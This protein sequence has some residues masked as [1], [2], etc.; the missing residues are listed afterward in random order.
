MSG[1]GRI[2]P[3]G[4][5]RAIRLYLLPGL[6]G[7]RI[8]L[9]SLALPWVKVF[10]AKNKVQPAKKNSFLFRRIVLGSSVMPLI[11]LV[12]DEALTRNGIRDH[13]AW[14]EIGIDTVLTARNGIEALEVLSGRIPD[15]LITDIRMPRMDGIDL[16]NRI[17]RR[18]PDCAILFLSGYS[19]EEYL[20]SAIKLKA[21][22]YVNKP[23]NLEILSETLGE[24]VEDIRQRRQ[25]RRRME[26]SS[27]VVLGLMMSRQSADREELYEAL[28]SSHLEPEYPLFCLIFKAEI[29][30][31]SSG[32]EPD[33]KQLQDEI[34][35]LFSGYGYIPVIYADAENMAV[36]FLFSVP[37]AHS[38]DRNSRTG[39][40]HIRQLLKNHWD[41]LPAGCTAALGE[42]VFSIEQAPRAFAAAKARLKT[43]FYLDASSLLSEGILSPAMDISLYN[44]A[45][46][47]KADLFRGRH[48]GIRE[49]IKKLQRELIEKLPP[50]EH[51]K[52]LLGDLILAIDQ[53]AGGRPDGKN[54]GP[55]PAG[56]FENIS[57]L[58]GCLGIVLDRINSLEQGHESGGRLADRA[59]GIIEN[60]FGNQNLS[61]TMLCGELNLTAPYLC[62]LFK[63]RHGVTINHYINKVRIETAG[64]FLASS[65]LK[66][67]DIARYCGFNNTNYFTRS[68][69]KNTGLLPTQYRRREQQ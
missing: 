69:K 18:F 1:A 58:D 39:A 62:Y 24:I 55:L 56:I 6:P 30:D 5:D 33:M 15:I 13:I 65:Q 16:A 68:F 59:R 19:D 21:E 22:Q 57:T 60:E 11:L 47:V 49:N 40:E 14:D 66:I 36:C 4:L 61:I 28:A 44:T 46:A 26:M 48:E 43:G 23:V 37:P 63:Q 54:E 2:K 10:A 17:R 9:L 25:E 41:R 51:A 20:R 12:D 64:N 35:S 38:R 50:V 67:R 3:F 45:N 42:T 8:P 52:A 53:C 32:E 7:K 34:N 29:S 31:D 27:R